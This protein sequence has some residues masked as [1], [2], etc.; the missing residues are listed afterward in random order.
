MTDPAAPPRRIQLKRHAGFSLQ[1]T[2]RNINGRPAQKV[3][4]TTAWGNPYRV[5]ETT[6]AATACERFR[7]TLA[8]WPADRLAD[9]LAP[10]RGKNLACWCNHNTKDCHAETLLKLANP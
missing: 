8:T 2:S 1:T 6:T 9:Y 3:D 4:R 10:L 5:D 7:E